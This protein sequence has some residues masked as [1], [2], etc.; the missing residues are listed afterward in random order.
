MKIEIKAFLASILLLASSPVRSDVPH[1]SVLPFDDAPALF[2]PSDILAI[3]N[4]SPAFPEGSES[5]SMRRYL[6]FY[7]LAY[8][9]LDHVWGFVD[10]PAGRVFVQG[11]EPKRRVGSLI[12]VHGYMEHSGCQKPFID[13]ALARG[14]AVY[15]MDLPG[16]GLSDGPRYDID[17]FE[18]YGSAVTV[19]A[20]AVAARDG[21]AE[22]FIA[23]AHST[24]CSALLISLRRN[25]DPFERVIL[26][27]PLIRS[28]SWGWSKLA[29][30]LGGPAMRELPRGDGNRRGDAYFPYRADPLSSGTFPVHWVEALFAWDEANRGYAAIPGPITVIQGDKDTV[31]DWRYN[32]AYLE[33]R[34]DDLE[35]VRIR[36]GTHMLFRYSDGRRAI[37]ESAL[38]RYL[39]GRLAE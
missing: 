19:F 12:F 23:V 5:D 14:W 37:V 17:D 32:L 3:R 18:D 33:E 6:E 9:G 13:D 8:P 38:D 24:G 39:G 31:V 27:A 1:S 4:E 7:S 36:N 26:G 25:G 34:V 2:G 30:F 35:V 28:A 16:H 11:F 15:L 21:P 29:K 20:A 10:G 22:R